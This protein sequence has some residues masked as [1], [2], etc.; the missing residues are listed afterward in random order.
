MYFNKTGS[1]YNRKVCKDF[2]EEQR[3]EKKENEENEI[4]PVKQTE[5]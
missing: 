2:Q 3:K 5:N 1:I 4:S